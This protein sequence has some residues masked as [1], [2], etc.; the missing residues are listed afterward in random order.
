[1]PANELERWFAALR[2][3]L[4][5]S[6]QRQLVVLHGSRDWCDGAFARLRRGDDGWLV[7]TDREFD[8]DCVAL[9]K[10][11]TRLG[12]EADLVALDLFRGF[13]PD[14]LCIAAGMAN[15]GGVLLLLAPSAADWQAHD[16][17]FAL[18]QNGLRSTAPRFLEYFLAELE[19]EPAIGLLLEARR[20][21]PRL[22]PLE[23][24]APTPVVAGATA[25]QQRA[26][27]SIEDWLRRGE[28]GVALISA[29][30][31]RGKSTA[32][33][34]LANRLR[35]ESGPRVLL[36]AASRRVA[37]RA[38][39]IAEGVDFWPPD[40]LLAEY[41]PA[42]PLIVDEAAMIP[43]SLL[44]QLCRRYPRL[45]MATTSGGYEGTGRGFRLRF[46]AGL[47][48]SRRLEIE[49]PEPVRWCA[50]DRL[51]AWL[52]RVMLLDDAAPHTAACDP[53]T[54]EYSRHALRD[55]D[56][57][58][59]LLTEVYRL[60]SSAH[61]RTRP[62]DL[63]MLMENPDLELVV[64]R[65]RGRVVGAALLNAEGGLDAG[66]GRQIHLGRRR[67]RGHLLAQMLTA[68]AGLESFAGWRGLRV[69]RIAV[70]EACRRRG[71]GRAL[72]A[73]AGR[74]A[75]S[76]G[77]G[78]LGASFALEPGAAAFWRCAGFDLVHVS[79]AAGKSSGEHS[80]AVLAAI[81]A[82]LQPALAQLGERVQRHLPTW[83]TQFLQNLDADAAT[84]L[85]RYS[86]FCHL[87][88]D[89]DLDEIRAFA[90]GR[91]GFE[92]AFACLQPWVMT[93]VARSTAPVDRLLIEKAVQN[94]DW[95]QLEHEAG[96]AARRSLERRLRGLVAELDKAC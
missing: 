21:L 81:D 93:A 6:R 4:A 95:S 35:R 94:R 43:Q 65:D 24:L 70:A 30:R 45:V 12:G 82:R 61:Y 88:A 44:R 86:G 18:W 77:L 7:F 55:G 56:A 54:L 53:A 19:T 92:S 15:A 59:A 38:L 20:E 29:G 71:I 33:G 91:R 31:G 83:M 26:L 66:L 72:L 36:C 25:A 22:P 90:H 84:A 41:S 42:D 51:E 60:L 5:A 28:T 74:L 76:R 1:M 34:L 2:Q 78:W 9:A 89:S 47:A 39:D 69:Q 3:Q 50:G 16:D 96:A 46:V 80:L 62:S 40:R 64:A 48:E 27:A 14:L 52:D 73:Q 63:R 57:P 32:L 68:Q 37:A 87:P 11:A 8:G 79:F 23:R 85:L 58:V 13:N 17:R 49:L 10:A 75:R 67:P